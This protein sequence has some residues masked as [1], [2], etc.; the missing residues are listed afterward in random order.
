MKNYLLLSIGVLAFLLGCQ[1][2][3]KHQGLVIEGQIAN[4]S[5]LQVYLDKASVGDAASSVLNRAELDAAGQFRLE[6]PEGLE[7]GIYRLRIGAKRVNLV[8]DGSEKQVRLSGDLTTLDRY[9]FDIQGS[10]DSRVY[11]D[12]MQALVARKLKSQD[13]Q[14]LVDSVSNPLV[15]M[16]VAYQS[17]GQNRGFLPIHQK[18]MERLKEAYPNSP[19]VQDYQA[20][21]VGLQ[22]I[23]TGRSYQ[24]F[25]PDQRQ[26]APDIRLP[27]PSGKEYALS[28][29]KGK[30]V[31]LDFWASWCG[32]CRRENPNVVKIYKKYKDQGFT[33]FSVSL[34]G[35]DSRTKAR[36]NSEELIQQQLE[37]SKQ[38]W[39]K[40]IEQD[41]LEWPYHVSD[42]KKWECAP[43]RLYGV[44]SIPRT[45]LIDREGRIAAVNLRGAEQIEQALLMVLEQS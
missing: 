37:I 10:K 13:I 24:F 26:P 4:A 38:R 27:S 45:F 25:P 18:A 8:L 30:V 14:N 11:R 32:P 40:A 44:T 17:L 12:V 33:V 2:E 21:L 36:F 35:L 1:G 29:L 39:V 7:P 42:L 20:H 19:Y 31:L 34:D 15:G 23:N 16:F 6:F 22:Q 28:D 9:D 41:G 5:N 3:P 43:A